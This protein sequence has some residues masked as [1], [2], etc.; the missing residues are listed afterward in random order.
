M[1]DVP[2]INF[3]ASYK[4]KMNSDDRNLLIGIVAVAAFTF[5]MRGDKTES[6]CA[7][8]AECGCGK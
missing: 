7:G 1:S 4:M 5:F 2:R 6:Y 3:Q 8:A